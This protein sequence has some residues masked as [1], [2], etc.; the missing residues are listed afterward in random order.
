[1]ETYE[2]LRVSASDLVEAL[3]GGVELAA[4]EPAAGAIGTGVSW[5]FCPK[6]PTGPASYPG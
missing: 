2:H 1:M 4:A 5:T 3:E 6:S